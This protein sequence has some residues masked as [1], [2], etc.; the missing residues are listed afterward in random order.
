M[1]VEN[2][3]RNVRIRASLRFTFAWG[4]DFE[5]FRTVDVSAGGARVVHHVLDSPRPPRGTVGECAFVLDGEEVRSEGVVVRELADGFVVKF[6]R[7]SQATERRIVAWI[8]RQEALAL[9][10]RIPA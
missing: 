5:L 10:R 7:V 6:V 8:F 4:E 9:S 2:R 1:I 3:R